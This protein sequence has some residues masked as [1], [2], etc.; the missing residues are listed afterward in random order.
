MAAD[1]RWLIRKERFGI[2]NA[3]HVAHGSINRQLDRLL[4]RLFSRKWRQTI[5]SSFVRRETALILSLFRILCHFRFFFF[6]FRFRVLLHFIGT[7]I[8]VYNVFTSWGAG[9]HVRFDWVF[10]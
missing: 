8:V 5:A 4:T 3:S 2:D 1:H 6:L 10:T 9:F 7:L